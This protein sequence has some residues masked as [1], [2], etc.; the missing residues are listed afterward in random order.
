MKKIVTLFGLF[1][2]FCCEVYQEP[3]LLSLSVEYVVDRI[4]KHAAENTTNTNELIFNPG[5]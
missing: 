4:T 1:L 2:V 5:G 3:T